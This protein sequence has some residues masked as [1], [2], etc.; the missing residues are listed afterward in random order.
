MAEKKANPDYSASAENLTNREL[1]GVQLNA[2]RYIV[3]QI[4]D[5]QERIAD[6]DDSKMMAD[7]VKQVNTLDDEIKQMVEKVGGYQDTKAGDYAL[8]Q[9][10][11]SVSYNPVKVKEALPAKYAIAVIDETVNKTHW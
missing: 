5:L 8:K 6:T 3:R 2:R 11:T 1:V 4:A 10:R 7:L 9:Q